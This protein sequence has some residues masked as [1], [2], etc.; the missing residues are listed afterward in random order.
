M[1]NGKDGDWEGNTVFSAHRFGGGFRRK[2]REG[3]KKGEQRPVLGVLELVPK[4]GPSGSEKIGKIA[5]E[6]MSSR[7]G[8]QPA[9]VAALPNAWRGRK[10]YS[11]GGKTICKREGDTNWG[12]QSFTAVEIFLGDQERKKRGVQE[13]K[14]REARPSE[15]RS[16]LITPG[17]QKSGLAPLMPFV[18][19]NER[20]E[21][22]GLQVGH[23]VGKTWRLA[24]TGPGTNHA[25]QQKGTAPRE[26]VKKGTLGEEGGK[27]HELKEKPYL[28]G[29]QK[30][31]K[32]VQVNNRRMSRGG[33]GEKKRN[34]TRGTHGPRD[35]PST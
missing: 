13:A 3:T 2:S 8:G 35:T 11:G 18:G 28:F 15:H 5:C 12:S 32:I 7:G 17:W 25:I 27:W 21:A 10:R 4:I 29:L 31:R 14:K 34:H 6:N 1:R 9:E 22:G 23:L 20:M 24:D 33:G 30:Q 19:C 26:K 16:F